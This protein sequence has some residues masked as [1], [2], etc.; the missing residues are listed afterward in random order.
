M[1]RASLKGLVSRRKP[2]EASRETI[3]VVDHR[4]T[5]P[6]WTAQVGK[7]WRA[8]SQPMRRAAGAFQALHIYGA[9]G[10]ASFGWGLCRLLRFDAVEFVPLWFAGGLFAYNLDRLRLDP[11]DAINTPDR[12][13]RSG[14]LRFASGA[15][16]GGAIGVLVV[17]PLL[18][19]QPI[20]ALAVALGTLVATWYSVPILGCRL[21]EIPVLKTLIPPGA[22]A[23]A[24]LAPVF[25]RH[26]ASVDL[27]LVLAA[28]WASCFLSFNMVLC[29]LRDLAGDAAHGIKSIPVLTGPAGSSAVLLGLLFASILLAMLLG[30]TVLAIL[31]ASYLSALFVAAGKSR[32]ESFYEWAVEGMLFLPAIAVL[33]QRFV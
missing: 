30:W 18:R 8:L 2:V 25:I 4:S 6:T 9:V 5:S 20:L 32:G 12:A 16:A 29:D 24:C 28:V 7:I 3:N 15:L 1:Q 31:T 23:A 19:R 10:I 14:I 13:R 33:A 11:A 27:P 21:K 26:S 22:V 17:L